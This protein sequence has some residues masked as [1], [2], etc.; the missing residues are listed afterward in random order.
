[1]GENNYPLHEIYDQRKNFV[2]VALTGISGSGCSEFAELMATPF[3]QWMDRKYIRKPDEMADM[4]KSAVKQDAVFARKYKTCYNLCERQ[5]DEPFTIVKYRNV[6]MFCVLRELSTNESVFQN[7][8]DRFVKMLE[9]KFHECYN[10]E[11]IGSK[12]KNIN[13]ENGKIF[14]NNK[15]I[16]YSFTREQI[17]ECG[18]TES[19]YNEFLN[20]GSDRGKMS[21]MFFSI[22]FNNFCDKLFLKLKQI[23]YFAKNYFVHRLGYTLRSTGRCE[24]GAEECRRIGNANIFFVV[25]TINEIIKGFHLN[26][27]EAPR[28]F[29][30]DSVRNSLEVMY[31]RERYNAFYMIALHNDG[32]EQDKVRQK[33][34]KFEADD[35]RLNV[36]SHNIHQLSRIESNINDFEDGCFYAQD[37]SRCVTESEI[38]IE[39]QSLSELEKDENNN[40]CT[41][42]SYGEQWMKFYSLIMHPGLIT[43]SRDERCMAI[44][45][46]AKFNSGCVS[47]QV[48]CTIVDKAYAV[49]SVGWND[50]PS[51]QI[52]CGLRYVNELLDNDSCNT[53]NGF[54]NGRPQYRIYSKFETGDYFKNKL[55]ADIN[56]NVVTILKD[57]GLPYPY[58][59]RSR[60]NSFKGNK[61][62]VNTRSLH[63]EENTMLR[64]SSVG[65]VGL[66]GGTMYVTASPCI[67][68]SKKA[69]QIGIRDIV[70]LDPYTDIAPDLILNC[71]FDV[72]TLRPFRGA[73]GST[74]Y[75][76]YQPFLPLKDEIAIIEK[77][78]QSTCSSK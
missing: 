67:L 65:G 6:L 10:E 73:F 32:R 15:S 64:I 26:N 52:P 8:L 23:N 78:N 42:F 61:D 36:L 3:S 14:I 2:I 39:Y 25:N 34:S 5:Y 60:Y 27:P 76:L 71:G 51:P 35:S 38:H 29:V 21:N 74:Y 33:V 22:E 63:A 28:R 24:P 19:L 69:Y 44:A 45:Y 20:L 47:R 1:M 72:P 58:C 43:P 59:F 11:K 41:F 37:I 31:L 53:V 77:Q 18:L 66:N 55:K 46:V 30:I 54:V 62:Q 49:Q 7:M 9:G 13:N 75:K 70:Y 40:A 4:Y 12:E 17:I 16:S 68:C 56:S 50:P 48:G 57:L